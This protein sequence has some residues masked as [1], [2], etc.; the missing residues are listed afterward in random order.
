MHFRDIFRKKKPSP[1][2]KAETVAATS[3][4]DDND[5]WTHMQSE[6]LV[7]IMGVTG[8]GKSYFINKLRP[9]SVAEGHGITSRECS[10][11]CRDRAD[12][13]AQKRKRAS[14]FNYSLV[15]TPLLQLTLL[16]SMTMKTVTPWSSPKFLDFSL[17][18]TYLGSS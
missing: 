12:R 9:N 2:S 7:L 13:Q 6:S 8:A 3:D 11:Q 1:S 4:D 14:L 10:Q 17:R 15:H 18:N 16:A 5:Q